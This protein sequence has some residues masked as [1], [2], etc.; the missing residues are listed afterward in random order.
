MSDINSYTF[1]SKTVPP[2]P[3]LQ[4]D[5]LLLRPC[6]MADADAICEI[7]DNKAVASTTGSVPSPYTLAMAK[8]WLEPQA[9]N[10]LSQSAAVFAICWTGPNDFGLEIVE[11]DEKA[12]MGYWIAESHWGKGVATEAATAVMKF[13]FEMLCLNKIFASHMVRNPA[14]GRVLEKIGMQKEGVF[15]DHVKKWGKFEDAV[16]YGILARDAQ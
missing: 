13:G 2:Q 7:L 8:A 14:S 16:F 9:N 10:W 5:R 15:R 6:V 12:E 1:T 4:T 3:S 11:Q